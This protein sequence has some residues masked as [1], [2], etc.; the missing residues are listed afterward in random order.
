MF[1]RVSARKLT[2]K[3]A[4][5]FFGKWLSY[6]GKNG[7][8]KASDYVKAKAAEYAQQLAEKN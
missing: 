5:F 7:D 2:K 1:E 8:E 6:E 4:K 3:Q